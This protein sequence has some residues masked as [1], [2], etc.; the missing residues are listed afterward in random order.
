MKVIRLGKRFEK[1][2]AG[3]TMLA[4]T[5]T[6]NVAISSATMATTTATGLPSL[7]RT[8]TGSQM[9]FP[10]MIAVAEVTAMPIKE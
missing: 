1:S 6:F 7:P 8:T 10:N 4:A 2:F 3:E 5:L 9:A